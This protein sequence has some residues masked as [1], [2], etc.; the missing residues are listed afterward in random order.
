MSG[1]IP[2]PPGPSRPGGNPFACKFSWARYNAGVVQPRWRPVLYA[3]LAIALIWGLAMAGYTI[4]RNSKMT[5]EKVQAY[6]ESVNLAKLSGEARARAIREL[7]AKI[8]AL[9]YEERRRARLDRAAWDLFEAMT[10]E[11]KAEFVELT[12]PTGFKQMLTAFEELSEERRRKAIDDALR[13]LHEARTT[14]AAA[15]GY[16]GPTGTNAQPV[17]SPELEARIRTIGLRAFY[18]QSSAA[19]KAELAPVLEELQRVME[20]G[21]P[22]RRR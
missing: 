11:E 18:S 14:L 22:F 9:T 7:A 2:E 3:A 8:N 21:R 19:T 16:G 17:L 5:A 4:A 20:S 1:A 6:A 10:E 12:L 13:R 15:E